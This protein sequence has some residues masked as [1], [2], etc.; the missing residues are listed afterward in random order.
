MDSPDYPWWVY[1]LESAL[2]AASFVWLFWT[3]GIS[4]VFSFSFQPISVAKFIVACLCVY[5]LNGFYKYYVRMIVRRYSNRKH[6]EAT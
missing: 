2:A 4:P 5:G 3:L 1:S 6:P